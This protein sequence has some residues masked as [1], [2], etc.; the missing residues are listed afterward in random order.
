MAYT[1]SKLRKN[2]NNN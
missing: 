1:S 2:Y